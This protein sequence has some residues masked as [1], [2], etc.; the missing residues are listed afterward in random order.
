[1]ILAKVL[2][3]SLGFFMA[4]AGS[5]TAVNVQECCCATC[6]ESGCCCE[7]ECSCDACACDCCAE[8]TDC[9]VKCEAMQDCDRATSCE[10]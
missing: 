6:C 9:E 8:A 3:V 4:Y 5:P 10:K 7:G 2:I 1:M